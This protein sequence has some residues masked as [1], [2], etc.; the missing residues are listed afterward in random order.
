MDQLPREIISEICSKLNTMD[1]LMFSKV[2]QYYHNVCVVPHRAYLDEILKQCSINQFLMISNVVPIRN[3]CLYASLNGQL[4]ILQWA[5]Q[6]GCHWD[7]W[8]CSS[9]ALNGCLEVLQWAC[10]NG[11]PHDHSITCK[12]IDNSNI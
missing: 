6:N 9:A 4:E 12:K 11:C 10:Q 7:W 8:V 5:R 2:S 3:L 1:L